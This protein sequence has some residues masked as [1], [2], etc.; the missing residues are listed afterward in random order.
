MSIFVLTT[1]FGGWK[2]TTFLRT[3]VAWSLVNGFRWFFL[4]DLE[5][6][7]LHSYMVTSLHLHIVWKSE[8]QR[9]SF[10]GSVFS[11]INRRNWLIVKLNETYV[12][13]KIFENNSVKIYKFSKSNNIF[14]IYNWKLQFSESALQKLKLILS[15]DHHFYTT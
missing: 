13:L 3:I 15:T 2:L 7:T 14:H 12:I 4:F 6:N 9:H 5:W 11:K 8:G 1:V 10:W